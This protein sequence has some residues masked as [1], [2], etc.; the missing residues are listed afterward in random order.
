M[1]PSTPPGFRPGRWF[2]G[3][4]LGLLL[5]TPAVLT[6]APD[7]ATLAQAFF[8]SPALSKLAIS[9]DGTHAAALFSSDG[10]ERVV[11]RPL[12][13]GAASPIVGLDDP[14]ARL[15]W[16]RWANDERLLFAVEEPMESRSPPRPRRT[17]LYAVNRDGSDYTH[18]ARN[19]GKFLLLGRGSFQIEDRITDW[20]RNDPDHV[21]ITV[22]K[23]TE[24]YP[25]VY[26][27]EVE[28]G[29]LERVVTAVDGVLYWYTDHDGVVRAG[30]GYEHG[31]FVLVARRSESDP[32]QTISRHG[33]GEGGLEFID[34]SYDPGLIYVRRERDDGFMA[35]YEYHLGEERLGKELFAAPGFDVPSWLEFSR[36]R[37]VLTAAGYY[38]AGPERH[39]FDDTAHTEHQALAG[40]L[41][42]RYTDIVSQ[43]RDRKVALVEASSPV[44]P[45]TYYL[46]RREAQEL[47]LAS[48][49][50]PMLAGLRM[51][52]VAVVSY[53]ARDGLEIPA[54]LTRPPVDGPLPTIIMPHGG[55]SVRDV[56]GFDAPAQYLAALGFAV[57]QP[58]YRGSTGYGSAHETAGHQQW[59]LAMQDDLTD[60]VRW[61]VETGVADPDRVAIY[62][63]SYGGYAALMG[64]VKTPELFRC[65]ASYA[66]P[67]DLVRM[68]NHDKGYL[69][70]EI[71]VPLIGGSLKDRE[72]L[73][74]TSPLENVDRIRVPVFLGHGEE[75]ERVS[76]SHS[77]LLAKA[78][79]RA[80]REVE[81]VVH[82]DVAHSFRDEASRIDFY[83]RLGRFLLG[84]TAP[85]PQA[86]TASSGTAR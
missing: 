33:Q 84:C 86:T 15:R 79:E 21:L 50:Y 16:L 74:E 53:P 42:G 37:R 19:W 75:D 45:T 68:L 82:E 78:L 51:S 52:E 35:L 22:R 81:L 58:N 13:G 48:E 9:P 26:R 39:F 34:F 65:G 3:W 72:R 62:G 67:S 59:G 14:E 66:G 76:V 69:F 11:V 83:T 1:P 24:A 12:D 38:A 8:R 77:T 18:L 70:S 27:M 55:P 49:S 73:R 17:R 2:G 5:F 61:L 85:R 56:L 46:Y 28:T 80:G 41:R 44:H 7:P 30:S 57:L 64:L 71:N 4:C 6:A 36:E 23:P 25:S 10:T 29:G 20:L 47:S 31:N 54:I 32:W 63:A 60:G 40:A 43:S